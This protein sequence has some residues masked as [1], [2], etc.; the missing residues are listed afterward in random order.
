MPQPCKNSGA[1]QQVGTNGYFCTCTSLYNGTNCE[2][3]IGVSQTKFNIQKISKIVNF[4]SV[5]KFPNFNE[6]GTL[7]SLP[8]YYFAQNKAWTII[9]NIYIYSLVW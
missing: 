2:T 1:C 7:L 6:N 5:I 3:Y 4:A 8:S 9:P